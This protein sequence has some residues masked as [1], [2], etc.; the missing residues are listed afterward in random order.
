MSASGLFANTTLNTLIPHGSATIS[1]GQNTVVIPLGGQLAWADAVCLATVNGY[2]SV[3]AAG[4]QLS[5]YAYGD[6]NLYLYISITEDR[7][8]TISWALLSLGTYGY[9]P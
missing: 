6:G 8:I 9:A 3:L 5:F 2:T 1:S 4:N 7:D